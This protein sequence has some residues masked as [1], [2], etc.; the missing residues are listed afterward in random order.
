[1]TRSRIAHLSVPKKF[2][3]GKRDAKCLMYALNNYYGNKISCNKD[4]DDIVCLMKK[5]WER[6]KTYKVEKNELGNHSG[7]WTMNVLET[8]VQV[9]LKKHLIKIKSFNG[10]KKSEQQDDVKYIRRYQENFHRRCKGKTHFIV[11]MKITI[12][13]KSYQH[14][15]AIRNG[16]VY[17]SY[18]SK[19]V[20]KKM[21][22]LQFLDFANIR[23]VYY[24]D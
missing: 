9:K 7:N 20:N 2:F 23:N 16:E 15:I 18:H 8:L 11:T 13:Q 6:K 14:A 12:E 5:Q 3:Q 4:W 24:I 21:Y 22:P 17:D 19:D 1:M 10:R